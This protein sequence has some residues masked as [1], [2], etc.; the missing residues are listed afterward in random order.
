[1]FSR[2]ISSRRV[3]IR[4]QFTIFLIQVTAAWL[5]I[6]ILCSKFAVAANEVKELLETL[7]KSLHLSHFSDFF[8]YC[9]VFFSD[10]C[11][12][13]ASTEFCYRRKVLQSELKYEV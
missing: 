6:L 5:I 13:E 1:M 2:T 4:I 3:T 9:W 10:V 11:L 7:G 12:S 8:L